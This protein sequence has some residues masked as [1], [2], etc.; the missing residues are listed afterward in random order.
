MYSWSLH[1]L[2]RIGLACCFIYTAC[3]VGCLVR[4]NNAN[5]CGGCC[6]FIG[7]AE[8]TCSSDG[9]LNGLGGTGFSLLFDLKDISGSGGEP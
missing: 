8:P 4:F 5:W 2:G 6:Y 9:D 7:I 1:D 3:V